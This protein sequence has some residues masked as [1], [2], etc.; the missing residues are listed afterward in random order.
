VVQ[1]KKVMLPM[2]AQRKH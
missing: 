2:V 1:T